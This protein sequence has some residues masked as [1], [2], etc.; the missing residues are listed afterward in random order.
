VRQIEARAFEK[1]QKAAEF[2]G[3]HHSK[4]DRIFGQAPGFE[5]P[6]LANVESRHGLD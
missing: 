1:V 5:D 2:V 4:R 3:E 6:A